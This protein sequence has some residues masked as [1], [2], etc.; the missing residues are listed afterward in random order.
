MEWLS[1]LIFSVTA[2]ILARYWH[3]T[4]IEKYKKSAELNEKSI[5]LSEKAVKKYCDCAINEKI[6]ES[7]K[8]CL[9]DYQKAE[10]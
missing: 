1:I 9:K 6:Q 10:K 5:V 4:K 3:L 8:E 2:I 7:F